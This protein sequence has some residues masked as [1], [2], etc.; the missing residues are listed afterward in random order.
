MGT[1]RLAAE[2]SVSAISM[3]FALSPRVTHRSEH[4]ML[5]RTRQGGVDWEEEDDVYKWREIGRD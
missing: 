4:Y 2:M 3:D 1:E 5:M